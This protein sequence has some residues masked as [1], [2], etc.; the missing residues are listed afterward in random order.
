MPFYL[1]ILCERGCK[2]DTNIQSQKS[3][4]C[5]QFTL[6]WNERVILTEYTH[7]RNFKMFFKVIF[8]RNHNVFRYSVKADWTDAWLHFTTAVGFTV[9]FQPPGCGHITMCDITKGSFQKHFTCI[10]FFGRSLTGCIT[11]ES[12]TRFPSAVPE[13]FVFFSFKHHKQLRLISRTLF[14][15][16][17]LA[18]GLQH[19]IDVPRSPRTSQTD[20]SALA[21]YTMRW[22]QSGQ[23]QLVS[24][25]LS[26]TVQV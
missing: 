11:L 3:A 14:I 4:W 17:S 6:N 21:K 2:S 13:H 9:T 18:V 16:C 10:H 26:V 1:F 5:L 12:K 20:S 7:A 24:V 25:E 19:I 8:S 15:S 22:V 23:N